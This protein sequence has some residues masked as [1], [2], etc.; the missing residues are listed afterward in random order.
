MS[1]KFYIKLKNKKTITLVIEYIKS[2][3]PQGNILAPFLFTLY[4]NDLSINPGVDIK[5]YA[6][7]TSN[8]LTRQSTKY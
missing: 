7:D 2:R 4:I 8:K 3:V 1:T 5:S 6:N